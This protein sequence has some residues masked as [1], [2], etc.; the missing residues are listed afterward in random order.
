MILKT[1]LAKPKIK[2]QFIARVELAEMIELGIKKPLL[3]VSA[4]SVYGKSST[5]SAYLDK[6]E[7]PFCWVSLGANENNLEQFVKY[8]IAAI[9]QIYSNFGEDI[10]PILDSPGHV[11]VSVLS[12]SLSNEMAELEK[13]IIIVFDDFHSIKDAAIT[14][15]ISE[16]L[17]Y[18]PQRIH[19]VIITRNDPA[20]QIPTFR[21]RDQIAEIR[22]DDL[23]FNE[24]YTKCL[25]ENK[26]EQ[27]VPK[28]F[29]KMIHQQLEGWIAGLN[30]LLLGNNS[31]NSIRISLQSN[32]NK[33]YS[34]QNL[35]N[36]VLKNQP[37]ELQIYLLVGASLG[38]F[39]A[40]LLEAAGYLLMKDRSSNLSGLSVVDFL[41]QSDLFIVSLDDKNEWFRFHHLFQ[42]YLLMNS[43]NRFSK[44]QI[45]NIS[46]LAAQWYMSTGNIQKT[47]E[48]FLKAEDSEHAIE[49]LGTYKKDLLNNCEWKRYIRILSLFPE[50][51]F[52]ANPTL[53]IAKCWKLVIQTKYPDLFHY[54]ESTSDVMEFLIEQEKIGRDMIGEWHT[55]LAFKSFLSQP[56]P[57]TILEHTSL[58]SDLLDNDNSF[59]RVYVHIITA[60]ALRIT[61][62]VEKAISIYDQNLEKYSGSLYNVL[63]LSGLNFNHWMEGDLDKMQIVVNQL[64]SKGRTQNIPHA[65]AFGYYFLAISHYVR[66]DIENAIEAFQT[67]HSHRFYTF[68][69]TVLFV[70]IGMAFAQHSAGNNEHAFRMIDELLCD[71]MEEGN[72][73]VVTIGLAAN[74]ELYLREENIEEVIKW[75]EH[76]SLGPIT[77]THGFY[78]PRLTYIKALLYLGNPENIT[79][80]KNI[81]LEWE[82]FLIKSRAKHYL[83]DVYMQ[84]ALIDHIE[85][86]DELAI[87]HLNLAVKLAQSNGNIRSFIDAGPQFIKWYLSLHKRLGFDPFYQT[88]SAA[89]KNSLK[90]EMKPLLSNREF[91]IL[92]EL[93][94]GNSNKKIADN[95]FIT[96]ATVKRHL[97]TIFSKLKVKNRGQAIVH[98]QKLGI[99]QP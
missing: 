44:E 49:I 5:I 42:S 30:M 20:L 71:A 62:R 6:C 65:Q 70:N 76:F 11:P 90:L 18:P 74:A 45:D 58:A 32:K 98:A 41:Q 82:E 79:L 38:E 17:T 67:A 31:I 78:N 21:I 80:A 68:G 37:E 87:D 72:D 50:A 56:E 39:S 47:I 69:S 85:Q 53:I 55:L 83:V 77:H 93:A 75:L 92:E 46:Q 15:L 73:Y 88:T 97:T 1:K 94:K 13:D 16:I 91:E 34:I 14:G 28:D 27:E 57:E 35:V 3:L 22:I 36:N 26:F 40:D 81:L 43:R 66:N 19:L 7:L 96:D 25:L 59:P 48:Y 84:H 95:L 4:P 33:H 60:Q 24:N 23:R 29:V 86:N 52:N 12:S 9:R 8:L 63:L 99:V 64:L 61:G 89:L 54:L 2:D 10:L 51:E